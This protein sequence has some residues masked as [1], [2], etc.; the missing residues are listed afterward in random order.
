LEPVE[1]GHE[2]QHRFIGQIPFKM[3]NPLVP[4][5]SLPNRDVSFGAEFEQSRGHVGNALSV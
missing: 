2:L 5:E 4:I 1:N 3:H